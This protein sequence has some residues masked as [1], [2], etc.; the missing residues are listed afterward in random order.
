M[1]EK[2]AKNTRANVSYLIEHEYIA[3]SDVPE[4]VRLAKIYPTQHQWHGLI[5][6]LLLSLGS[7]AIAFS[8]VFFVAAN[9]QY[10]G[11]FG[12][13][14]LIQSLIVLAVIAYWKSPNNSDMQNACLMFAT[15]AV[16]ALMALFGQVYQTGADPWQLFFNWALLTLPW[17]LI[18]RFTALWMVWIAL[19][20]ATLILYLADVLVKANDFMWLFLFFAVVMYCWQLLSIKYEWLSKSWAINLLGFATGIY[21]TGML[22]KGIFD[23]HWLLVLLWIMWLGITFYIY[24]YK[25]QNFVILSGLCLSVI[26]ALNIVIIR[27][28]E[29]SL[30]EGIFLI[31][32]IITISMATAMVIWLKR[33]IKESQA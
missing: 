33:L 12:K 15:F 16:G 5:H 27:L 19:L 4:A 9:W 10:L 11:Q 13:F 2:G 3:Q 26:V 28:S 23:D 21:A 29:S 25:F 22:G 8:L 17:V 20:Y 31:N 30:D 6:R 14:A 18:S 1:I 32:G 7:L 24:R